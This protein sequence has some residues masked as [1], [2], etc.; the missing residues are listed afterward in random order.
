MSLN[1]LTESSSWLEVVSA[2]TRVLHQHI[3][4]VQRWVDDA[5]GD[6]QM[7]ETLCAPY[8]YLLQ[9]MYEEDIPLARAIESSDLLIHVS[10]PAVDEPSP[11]LALIANIFQSV[12]RQVGSV[13]F[14]IAG[15]AERSF[16]PK[17]IDLGLAAFARG[18]LYLGFSMPPAVVFGSGS[19]ICQED[20]RNTTRRPTNS[21]STCW[22]AVYVFTRTLRVEAQP[23]SF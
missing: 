3:A 8:E 2:K 7:L 15:V 5:G 23:S 9:Q 19:L 13:A 10:G 12:R 22:V 4:A 11:S 20:E 16:L 1:A 21:S 6:D 17:D 14:A 18:S